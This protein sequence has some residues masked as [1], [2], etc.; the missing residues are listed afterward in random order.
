MGE[1]VISAQSRWEDLVRPLRTVVEV[2][3]LSLD[4]LQ[5]G[6]GLEELLLLER[7]LSTAAA[8]KLSILH[9]R[10]LI[11]WYGDALIFRLLL[12]DL[13][14]LT[15]QGFSESSLEEFKRDVEGSVY[16][17]LDLR[18][19]K[20]RCLERWGVPTT[21]ALIKLFL[22]P[23]ALSRALNVSL[24]ELEEG[25]LRESKGDCKVVLLVPS[26]EIALN[27]EYLAIVG[28]KAMRQWQAFV[29][30]VPPDHTGVERIHSEAMKNLKWIHFT[31]SHLTPR[32]LRV[33]WEP[34]GEGG[35]EE[36]PTSHAKD[37]IASLLYAHLFTC[38]LLYTA[39]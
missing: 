1:K 27:G 20:A 22:F 32:Q 28:G 30:N 24:I 8:L 37:P 17:T 11:K 36:I 9:M 34:H 14:V 5:S 3:D 29:P 38:C 15:L 7:Q 12:G 13:V 2:L 18:L 39:D 4:K 25:L 19:N 10:E 21:Y 16:L 31:L 35:E 26:H 23:E 33:A 6:E